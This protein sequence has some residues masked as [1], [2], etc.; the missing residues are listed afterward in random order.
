MAT[1]GPG[2]PL[3]LVDCPDRRIDRAAGELVARQHNHPGAHV[4]VVLPR[5]SSPP[6]LGR[7][8]HDRTADKIARLVSRIPA[9]QP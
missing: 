2:H 5:R 6:L 7:L 4:T 8:L 9:R 3:D 1:G